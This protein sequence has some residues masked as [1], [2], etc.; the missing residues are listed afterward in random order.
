MQSGAP[1]S[2][3]GSI[4]GVVAWSVAVE[5]CSYRLTHKGKPVGSHELKTL[6]KGRV[7]LLEARAQYQGALGTSSVVQRSRCAQGER[8]SQRFREEWTERSGQRSFDVVFDPEQ[9]LVTASRGR[10]QATAPYL[11]PYRDPLSLLLELRELG[12]REHAVLPLLGKEVTVQ[13]VGE[14]ELDTH[15]GPRNAVAYLLHPGGSVVYVQRDA[16][17]LLL[18]F[19]QRLS[20]GFVDALLV[21]V[22]E[23]NDLEDF[24]SSKSSSRRGG[25]KRRRRSRRRPRRNKRRDG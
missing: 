6:H 8:V 3:A 15:V 9:G 20:D 12:P 5:V 25:G 22:G 2:R 24:G 14:V 23:E 7:T 4:G 16:P 13:R 17:H 19:T 1:P 18:K 11:L 10:D 21:K